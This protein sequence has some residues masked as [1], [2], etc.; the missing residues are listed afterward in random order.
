MAWIR[1]CGGSK[2]PEP[3]FIIVNGILQTGCTISGAGIA[4]GATYVNVDKWGNNGGDVVLSTPKT[5]YSKL[6]VTFYMQNTTSILHMA[7][8]AK[9]KVGTMGS[10]SVQTME[11]TLDPNSDIVSQ[12]NLTID[13]SN[14]SAFV[15][16]MA[17]LA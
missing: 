3:F 9:N 13:G 8:N 12:I 1:C 10:T 15:T 14:G 11:L 2:A 16:Q 17:L 7:V 4:Q 6:Q 5:G